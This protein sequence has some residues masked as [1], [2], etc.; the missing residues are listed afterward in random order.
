MVC[1]QP[2]GPVHNEFLFKGEINCSC[3]TIY[4]I[5][6]IFYK[7]KGLKLKDVEVYSVQL[8]EAEC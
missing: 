5:G 1:G 3:R 7:L 4:K 2:C 8:K 6:S